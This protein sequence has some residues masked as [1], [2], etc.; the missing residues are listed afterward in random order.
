MNPMIDSSGPIKETNNPCA[1]VPL[2]PNEFRQ[3]K[4]VWSAAWAPTSAGV[5]IL[6]GN[7]IEKRCVF[8]LKKHE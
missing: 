5:S 7:K 6:D 4:G 1:I 2:K 8:N 3:P